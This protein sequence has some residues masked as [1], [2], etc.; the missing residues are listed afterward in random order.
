MPTKLSL[1][2]IGTG[3]IGRVHAGNVVHRLPRA[4][5]IAL[6]DVDLASA[7]ACAGEFGV[8]SAVADYRAILNDDAIDAVVVC[9][10]TDTHGEIIEAAARARKHV[11]CEKPISL[12]LAAIDRALAAVAEAGVQ[13]QIGFNRRFDANFRRVREAVAAEEIG[14]PHI[15][16]L[17]SRDPSPPPI[18]YVRRS[19]GMFVDMTI[20]DFDMARFL[21]GSEV[22]EIF[23]VAG[24]RI[25]PEIGDAGDVDTAVITLRFE[26]GVIG[27]IDNSRKAV[28]GYDQR[29]EVFGSGGSI[30]TDNV[31]PNAALLSGDGS[32]RRDLPLHF[33]IERYVESYVEELRLF[34]DA[35]LDGGDVPVTGNDG[36]IP[37][38]MG[39]A[40]RMSHDENRPVRLS[41]VS[42]GAPRRGQ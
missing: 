26:N 3:R 23:T 12:D 31:Y 10:S 9:T 1:G 7:T 8:P 6:A 27:T 18:E 24:V 41:E 42:Y 14:E 22:E 19:G 30:R 37:V 16:H 17:I 4:E 35:V 40:A 15:L 33:F 11:F 32:V 25:D 21:I 29:A 34:V 20:H 13:L 2:L 28:Y 38:V 39:L 5:L 36:R